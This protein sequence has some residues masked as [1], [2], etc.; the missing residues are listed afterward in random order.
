VA[1]PARA[2]AISL[3]GVTRAFGARPA[4]VG[5][6]LVV[7]RGE[8]VLLRGANGAGK[9]TLL[10]VVATAWCFAVTR[11]RAGSSPSGSASSGWSPA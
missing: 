7:E 11:P 6:R 3:N 2:P 8:V 5:V 10:R 4:I 1:E 9:S